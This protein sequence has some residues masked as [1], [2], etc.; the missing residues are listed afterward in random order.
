MP[1]H[2]ISEPAALDSKPISTLFSVQ[3][4]GCVVTGASFGEKTTLIN[5]LA[6]KGFQTIA[7]VVRQHLERAV[8]KRRT[9]AEIRLVHPAVGCASADE[10]PTVGSLTLDLGEAIELQTLGFDAWGNWVVTLEG[11]LAGQAGI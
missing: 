7:E 5:P 6:D 11:I 9:I 3:T 8:A 4:N 10:P 2:T 1:P